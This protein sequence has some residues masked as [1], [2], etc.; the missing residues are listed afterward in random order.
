[1]SVEEIRNN[2]NIGLTLAV[3][4]PYGVPLDNLL[5]E[6]LGYTPGGSWPLGD[7]DYY[8]AKLHNAQ[9][10]GLRNY[11]LRQPGYFT[12]NA[13]P[14]GNIFVYKAVWY[15]WLN[16]ATGRTCTVLLCHTDLVPMRRWRDRYLQTRT[17]TTRSVRAADNLIRQDRALARQD[18]QQVR[19][20]QAGMVQDGTL[21]EVVTGL[22]GVPHV[23]VADMLSLV[24][25]GS[26]YGSAQ[27]NFT[28]QA[29]KIRELEH[30]LAHE[31]AAIVRSLSGLIAARQSLP[32]NALQL[33]LQDASDRL[34]NLDQ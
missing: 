5:T 33:A 14:F 34:A 13:Q 1:M 6:V 18:M 23:D 4:Y 24:S 19:N 11:E 2:L 8:I 17:G 20:I 28:C 10:T 7:R 9:R 16:P 29:Q 30:K 25:Q 12:I 15:T 27:F 22:L 26:P 32:G 31:Q 3:Q 21:S